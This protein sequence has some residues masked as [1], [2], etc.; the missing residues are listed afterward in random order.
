MSRPVPVMRNCIDD[1]LRRWGFDPAMYSALQRR[2]R[3][4]G[5]I[6]S[7]VSSGD[8]PTDA[9]LHGHQ[10]RTAVRVTIGADGIARNCAV[11]QSSGDRALDHSTCEVSRRGRFDPA[12]DAQGRPVEALLVYSITWMIR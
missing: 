2:P 3:S 4:V 8:Y 11:I 12:L 6:A 5:H 10:G 7:W 1:Q 9:L